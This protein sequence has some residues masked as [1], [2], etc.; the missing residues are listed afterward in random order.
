MNR[1][2]SSLLLRWGFLALG[3][4]LATKLVPGIACHDGVTLFVVVILLSFLNAVLRPVLLLFTLP[5]ILLTAGFGIVV[6]NALLFYFVGHI[7]DGFVV[8]GFWPA[9]WGSLVVSI[10]NF[11][12][13]VLI[14]PVTRRAAP[15]SQQ[16]PSPPQA[17]SGKGGGDVIDI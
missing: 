17:G 11:I 13:N 4:T 12:L 14:K 9:V 16:P 15:P 5:L 6:I 2:L 8:A 10:T 7:V 3:V 1:S